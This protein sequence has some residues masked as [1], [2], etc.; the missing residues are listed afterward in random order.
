MATAVQEY[1]ETCD[2]G[3]LVSGDGCS[4]SARIEGAT[5][6]CSNGLDD[7]GDGLVDAP[8][9]PGCTDA[10]DA[11]ERGTASCD[12]GIDNDGDYGVDVGGDIAC[13]TVFG[14]LET[15]QCQDGIDNDGDG[16]VDF[17]GGLHA[18]GEALS[19]PDPQCTTPGRNKEKPSQ[20]CGLGAELRLPAAALR[21]AVA[22]TSGSE[23]P[24][25]LDP[26]AK[27]LRVLAHQPQPAQ[28]VREAA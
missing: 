25:S 8:S 11:S 10:N 9:D 23:E 26:L 6:A 27:P 21:L 3:N 22:P 19:A 4:Q 7:D 5:P 14:W 20:G 1:D 28:Q 12:D 13:A 17:D 16:F 15:A 24:A 18:H 2:D